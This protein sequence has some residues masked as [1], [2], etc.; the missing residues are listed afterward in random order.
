MMRNAKNLLATL[1]KTTPNLFIII[2]FVAVSWLFHPPFWVIVFALTSFQLTA[3]SISNIK[4]KKTGTPKQ[5]FLLSLNTI[6]M[7]WVLYYLAYRL[8]AYGLLGIVILGV[9][10]S[11]YIL[12]RQRAEYLYWVEHIEREFLYGGK[13]ATELKKEKKQ[14]VKTK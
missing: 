11:F 2:I 10:M 4:E 6:I 14:K 3:Y 7:L 8:G 5:V 12:W 9:L 13:T 1:R